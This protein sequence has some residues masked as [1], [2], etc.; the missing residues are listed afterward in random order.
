MTGLCR[1]TTKTANELP[2]LSGNN[3]RLRIALMA[4]SSGIM[5]WSILVASASKQLGCIK[6]A[7]ISLGGL[8]PRVQN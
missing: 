4:S 1:F 6:T 3:V 7:L 8:S 2:S 5:A